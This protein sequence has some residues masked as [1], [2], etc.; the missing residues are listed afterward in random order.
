M[1]HW[2][3]YLQHRTDN[4]NAADGI[5]DAHQR[6]VQGRCDIPHHLPTNE[7]R[8]NKYRQ[9]VQKFCRG[10]RAKPPQNS[11]GNQPE[12]SNFAAFGRA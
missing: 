3:R 12:N 10:H 4:D 5:R 6:R 1:L 11:A 8:Q 9:M 2:A 7:A